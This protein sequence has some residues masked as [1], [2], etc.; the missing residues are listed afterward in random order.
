MVDFLCIEARL[1][2]ELDGGQHSLEVDGDR[3]A[4]LRAQDFEMLRFWN[5]EVIDSF[6][7]VLSSISAVVAARIEERPTLIQPSPARGRGLSAAK[8]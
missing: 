1:I 5:N 3:T 6:E 2:V 8:D 4:Y 7:G